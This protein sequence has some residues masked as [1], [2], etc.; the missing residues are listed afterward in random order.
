MAKRLEIIALI[1][2][3]HVLTNPAKQ[4]EIIA[5][6]ARNEKN[7]KNKAGKVMVTKLCSVYIMNFS[8]AGNI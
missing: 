6:M 1:P 4:L 7:E 3:I 8:A 5:P 2:P